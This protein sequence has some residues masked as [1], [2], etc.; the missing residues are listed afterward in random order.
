MNQLQ[1]LHAEANTGFRQAPQSLDAESSILGGI[2]IDGEA[3]NKVLEFLEADHFYK[4]SHRVIYQSLLSLFSDSEPIDVVSVANRLSKQGKLDEIGGAPYLGILAANTP[5]SANIGH[6]AQIVREKGIMRKL[7]DAG[8]EIIEKAYA[9]QSEVNDLLD[10][11]EKVIF[12]IGN[13]NN[14]GGFTALKDIVKI[15]FKQIEQLYENKQHISGVATGFKDL[16][17]IT[18]GLQPADLIIVAGRPS[19]GKTSLAL[20]MASNAAIQHKVPVAVFSLEMSKESLVSRM[21]CSEGMVDAGKVR[22]GFLRESDWPKLTRA[23]AR[24]SEAPLFI[25]DTSESTIFEMR[26]KARRLKKEHGLGLIIVDYLQLMRGSSG[27]MESREREISEISR[28][29]KALA[30]ELNIPVVALSQLNRSLESRQD[31][32]PMPSDLRE[33]GAIEQDADLISFVY[34][35]EVYNPGTPDIGI[36]EIIIAKHRNGATGT[37][38]VKF[39]KE[40]TRFDNLEEQFGDVMPDV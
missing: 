25:D 18:H 6:Y 29:L 21:L 23:A 1:H 20:N 24:L 22:G 17:K 16:D 13:E 31:K 36:A 30:K 14:Q 39:F 32:R 37:V 40:Y 34:R 2:L 19:M 38:R 5:S 26:T 3:I 28:G 10:G 35:D 27:K 15:S 9:G 8:N 11:A 4:K 12:E 7:I 33:S